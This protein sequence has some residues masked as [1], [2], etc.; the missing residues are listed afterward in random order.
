MRQKGMT[1]FVR[2]SRFPQSRLASDAGIAIGPILFIISVLGILAAAIAAGSGSFTTGTATESN[3][4]KAAAIIDIGQNLKIGFDR[5]LGNGVDFSTVNIDPD[6]TSTS[7]D[8]FSPIGGGISSPSTTMAVTSTVSWY[9]P[10]VNIPKLG[11]G[12]GNR[13]AVLQVSEEVC[14]EINSKVAALA[15]GTAKGQ[16]GNYGDFGSSSL[17]DSSWPTSLQG[18][19]IGCVDNTDHETVPAGFYFYQVLG[20]Q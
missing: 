15:T 11:T 5:I 8:L 3:R 13:L 18:K 17:V 12:S 14:D 7:D 2:S 19:S 20:I 4:A 1:M 10:L 16:S 9:Y 6:N